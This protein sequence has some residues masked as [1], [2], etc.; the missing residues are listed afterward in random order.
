MAQV[1]PLRPHTFRLDNC[2]ID[3]YAA[4]MGAIGV[5]IY[6]VLQRYADRTTGQ[7]WPSVS[8]IATA[9]HLSKKCVKTY[10]HHLAQLGLIDM[11]PRYTAA[12][13]HTSNL[14]TVHD[15]THTAAVLRR[16][17]QGGASRTGG[18]APDT[19]PP[20]DSGNVV[21]HRRASGT[22]EQDPEEQYLTS[23]ATPKTAEHPCDN[24]FHAHWSPAP[25]LGICLDCF[26]SWQTPL[27]VIPAAL[28][29][30]VNEGE[31]QTTVGRL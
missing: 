21:P 17:Q 27:E 6:A 3:Q 26:R 8:T 2:V 19:P 7:C 10:L 29:T 15:P 30:E 31:R 23:A 5:A 14:Y 9:L 20:Q 22:P 12:G 25:G 24:R 11:A 4:E 28:D 18:G 16:R 1:L 13:D